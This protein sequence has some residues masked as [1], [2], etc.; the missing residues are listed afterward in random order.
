MSQQPDP[1]LETGAADLKP[2]CPTCNYDLAGTLEVQEQRC[3]ECGNRW[4][5]EQLSLQYETQQYVA[6]NPLGP[7]WAFTP[8]FIVMLIAPIG[9]LAGPVAFAITLLIAACYSWYRIVLWAR[10][11]HRRSY[12]RG[13][14]P[15]NRFLYVTLCTAVLIAVNAAWI[16][17]LTWISASLIVHYSQGH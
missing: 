3:P 17:V 2:R 11:L 16:A 10:E 15:L 7:S 6:S 4:T 12:A 1:C 8:G 14:T 5:I 13:R 9:I